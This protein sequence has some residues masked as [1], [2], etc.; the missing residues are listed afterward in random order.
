[1]EPLA[2]QKQALDEITARAHAYFRGDWLGLPVQ[3]RWASLLTGPSGS[4]K[5]AV[6]AMA[7]DA[8]TA[9]LLRVSAP[10]WMPCGS[11]NRGTR[12]TIGVI[13]E[14]VARHNRTIFFCDETDKL[15]DRGGDNSWKTYI[16]GEF[17]DLI[18]GRWPSGLTLPETDDD[19]PDITIEEL[20]QKLRDTVFVLAA[21]T[22]Q[23]W[24]DDSVSRRTM[25][26]GAEIAPGTDELSAEIIAEKLPR[27]LANRFNSSLIR[28]P[29]LNPADYFRIASEA[30]NKLPAHMRQ[31]F[32]AEVSKRID[33]AIAA[34]KGVRFL[35]EAMMEVLK[36][37]PASSEI[38]GKITEVGI[39]NH[40][41][42][43]CTL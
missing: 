1:M 12:E 11:I 21:G 24:F 4:G 18:D 32:R 20:N 41:L 40:D 8:V 5:T 6:A 30:E 7:A 33:G 15:I 39:K 29:E 16:R 2:H 17:F 37:L 43:P 28:I 14:H 9:S 27:E 23:S 22:F 10:N 31:A 35:E 3:P 19:Q 36:T 13:A 26:F 42:E 34:K 25:G 38:I